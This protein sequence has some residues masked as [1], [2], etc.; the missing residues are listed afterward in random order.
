MPLNIQGHFLFWVFKKST[1]AELVKIYPENP[2]PKAIQKVIE[3]LKKGGVIIYPTDTVY[4]F[5]CDIT[6]SR[7][8]EQVARLKNIKIEKANFSIIFSD[9]SH[10]SEYTKQV[11]T[12]TYKLLNRALPGPYTFILDASNAIPKIFKS[13]KKT[14]GIRIPDNNIPR[15]IVSALGN[16]IIASSVHDEDEI[17]DYTTDPELILEKYSN[18]VDLVIDGGIGDNFASTVVDLTSGNPEVIR[19]GKGDLSIL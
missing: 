1:M 3:V 19:E 16:P 15:E 18:V 7:A 9:L 2:N 10:L 12:P 17:I 8:L 14:I 13:K 4:S 6:K 11:D 5:G